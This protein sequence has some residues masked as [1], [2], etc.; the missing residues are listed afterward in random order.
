MS[1]DDGAADPLARW[2]ARVAE[3]QA[4]SRPQR[5]QGP[6]VPRL[7]ILV[8][9]ILISGA[10]GLFFKGLSDPGHVSDQFFRT[11][12][13]V[14]NIYVSDPKIS[15]HVTADVRCDASSLQHLDCAELDLSISLNIPRP[16]SRGTVFI[17]S[18]I[19]A[20]RS[21][22]ALFHVFRKIPI[23]TGSGHSWIYG[24]AISFRT[25]RSGYSFGNELDGS[26]PTWCHGKA[27]QIAAEVD[28][29]RLAGV[30]Q[31]TNSNLF[32]HLPKLAD[33]EGPST[34]LPTDPY[35]LA[36]LNPA[37]TI[38]GIIYDPP[39]PPRLTTGALDQQ[40]EPQ[41]RK[42]HGKGFWEPK[43]FSVT[44][45]LKGPEPIL[46]NEQLD[47]SS[48]AADV[49]SGEY[50]WNARQQISPVIKFT[51]PDASDQLST[52][53]FVSGIALGVAGAAVIAVVQE[54]P[55]KVPLRLPAGLRLRMRGPRL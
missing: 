38:D 15:A 40:V 19:R 5:T 44:E 30:V 11:T 4:N 2:A 8:A 35:V 34:T 26:C 18:T 23:I 43:D 39:V 46:A 14:I 51:N 55:K 50:V 28:S 22:N 47:F 48:P 21:E 31:E 25:S 49:H 10:F 20:Q 42:D 33:R 53:V 7:V 6:R 3:H 37:S 13:Q 12:P 27:V 41:L 24:Q 17:T 52:Y 54:A 29:F 9:I 16:I 1:H 32:G 36:A 45:A